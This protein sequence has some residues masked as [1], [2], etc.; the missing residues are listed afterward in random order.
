[1]FLCSI[2]GRIVRVTDEVVDYRRWIQ[3]TFP[4]P[5]PMPPT[6]PITPS[7][8]ELPSAPTEVDVKEPSVKDEVNNFRPPPLV[9]SYANVVINNTRARDANVRVHHNGFVPEIVYWFTEKTHDC[10]CS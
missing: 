2:L 6:P 8:P 5:T 9:K 10:A 7:A 4:I 3:K 1:M